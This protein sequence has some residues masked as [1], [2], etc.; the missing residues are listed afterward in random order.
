MR[1]PNASAIWPSLRMASRVPINVTASAPTGRKSLAGIGHEKLCS[2]AAAGELESDVD[3]V[4]VTVDNEWIASGDQKVIFIGSRVRSSVETIRDVCSKAGD[5]GPGGMRRTGITING[6]LRQSFVG[7]GGSDSNHLV[8]VIRHQ[9]RYSWHQLV[10]TRF[11][12]HIPAQIGPVGSFSVVAL[13]PE[14][15]VKTL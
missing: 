2:S 13:K 12:V 9:I 4:I 10:S 1:E 11:A 7:V 8:V 6:G 5:D 3:E 15:A 14:P